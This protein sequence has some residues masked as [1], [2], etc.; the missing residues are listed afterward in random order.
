MRWLPSW[1]LSFRFRHSLRSPQP[2]SSAA[3]EH[4][5][6][7]SLQPWCTQ[8]SLRT[9]FGNTRKTRR[10]PATPR[11]RADGDGCARAS[12]S[13]HAGGGV[14]HLCGWLWNKDW[15]ALSC[16]SQELTGI[17]CP[18]TQ[19]KKDGSTFG[20]TKSWRSRPT[21]PRVEEAVAYLPKPEDA[22]SL[23]ATC[24]K[25]TQRRQNSIM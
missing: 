5:Q 19:G 16:A 4:V 18:V 22:V 7:L 9:S 15:G 1:R 17:C 25:T 3:A 11:Q 13:S 24:G 2:L 21:E 12:P 8:P 10:P 23:V 20:R 14:R 6:P